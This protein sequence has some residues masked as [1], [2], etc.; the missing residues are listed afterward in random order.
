M[1]WWKIGFFVMLFLFEGAREVAVA[2]AYAPPK[3]ANLPSVARTGTLVRAEGSWKRINEGSALLPGAVAITCWQDEGKCYETSYLYIG[4]YSG[5]P[6]L[7]VYDAKFTDNAVTYGEAESSCV[8][9]A[10]RIDL[11][12][13]RVFATRERTG[14][15]KDPACS[16]LEPRIEMT[17]A[18]GSEPYFPAKEHFLPIMSALGLFLR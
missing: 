11:D 14:D 3:I 10:V 1:N 17:F 9:Y 13:K 4:G 2:S 8:H 15:A 5:M 16:N 6:N 18:D 7:D 12:L